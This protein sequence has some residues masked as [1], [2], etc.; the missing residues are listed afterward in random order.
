MKL[1]FLMQDDSEIWTPPA[2]FLEKLRQEFPQVEIHLVRSYENVRPFLPDAEIIV[3]WTLRAHQFA[4]ARKLRWIHSP[5]AALHGVL[6][7]EVVASDV[8]VTNSSDVYGQA[9]ADHAMA[10][11][12]AM[13][14]HLPSSLRYQQKHTW[15]QEELW[16]ERPAFREISGTTLGVVGVGAIGREV[17]RRALPLECG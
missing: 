11:L 8:V 6:I 9:V 13:A 17:I 1:L 2:W 14:R 5:A 15:A 12:L 4:E 3:T 16:R 10:M 7:P